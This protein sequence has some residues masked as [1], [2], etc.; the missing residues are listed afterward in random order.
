[1]IG[2][3]IRPF[4][5]LP[6]N[7][8]SIRPCKISGLYYIFAKNK[9]EQPLQIPK[10]IPNAP[11]TNPIHFQSE[12]RILNWSTDKNE[13]TKPTFCIK[14]LKK[15]FHLKIKNTNTKIIYFQK[16]SVLFFI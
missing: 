2:H 6:L 10:S 5:T 12:N 8:N 16:F 1:M 11:R 14:H 7:K 3:I 15:C 4:M 9:P 13:R